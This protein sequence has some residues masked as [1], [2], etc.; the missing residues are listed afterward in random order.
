MSLVNDIGDLMF[1]FEFD[2][3]VLVGLVWFCLMVS[4]DL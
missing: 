3:F 1:L 2:V 4:V